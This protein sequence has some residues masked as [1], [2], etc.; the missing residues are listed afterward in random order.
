MVLPTLQTYPYFLPLCQRPHVIELIKL[1]NWA[2]LQ[3]SDQLM[4]EMQKQECFFGFK[5]GPIRFPP[6]YRYER[7]SREYSAQKMRIPA[8]CDRVLW[9]S[10]PGHEQK[11]RQTAY[12]CVDE[13]TT[14]D[15]SPVYATFEVCS[16]SFAQLS[17]NNN[18]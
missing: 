3:K 6:T 1:K 4:R 10:L 2:A 13:I 17:N 18:K 9:R 15:H 8:W 7:G 11:L 5:E 16:L 14:S 12:S